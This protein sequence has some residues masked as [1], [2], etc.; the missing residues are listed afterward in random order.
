[1]EQK[2][3]RLHFTEEEL[4][5][6]SVAR[7]A[8]KAERTADKTD[9][10]KEKLPGRK[11]K[12]RHDED[13]ATQR[14]AQLRFGKK[15]FAEETTSAKKKKRPKRA[16]EQP[17]TAKSAQRSAS[18]TQTAGKHKTDVD[19]NTKSEP[20][21]DASLNVS[22]RSAVKRSS[23]AGT[24]KTAK[25]ESPAAS[26]R[27]SVVTPTE[28]E[29]L[30]VPKRTAHHAL[31]GAAAMVAGQIHRQVSEGNEDDNVGTQAAH[32]SEETVEG[33]AHAV[34]HYHYSRKLKAYDK[35]AKLERRSDK[36]NVEALYQNYRANHP[37]ASSNP[38]S[39]WRQ[40][41]ELH[42]AYLARKSGAHAPGSAASSA[43]TVES[44][45]EKAKDALKTVQNFIGGKRQGAKLLLILCA[46]LL[47]IV[48]MFQGCSSLFSGTVT[49]ITSTSWPAD[50]VEISKADAYYTKLEAQL[51]KKINQMESTNSSD[52]YNYSLAE[53]GHDST[54][55]ISYLSAKYGDFT[56]RE[57]KSELEAIFALQYDLDVETTE[58]TRTV[59]K[60]VRAG[61]YIGEVVTSGYCSCSIC[62]G[63]WAGGPTASGVYPTANHT[64]AVDA[65]NPTVPIG[66][67]IIMNGTLYKVEDTGAFD[68]Y[69]VDFDVY[70]DSHSA[71]QAHGHQT[72]D[73]YYAGGDGEE[74]EVTTT[75]DVTV[76]YV[77]LTAN[78]FESILTSRLTEEQ[79]ELYD[80]YQMTKGNRVFF[81]TP[82]GCDWHLNIV[83]NYGFRCE[84]TSIVE[85]DC[86]D[87][88]VLSGMDVL[89]VM[90]GTVKSISNNTVVLEAENDCQVK[91]VGCTDISVSVGSVVEKG[92]KIASVGS[93]G[94]LQIS[95]TYEGTSL[96][97]YFYLDTGEGTVY[98]EDVGDATGK[99]ALLI[100]K[101]KEY[102]G[103]PYVWGGYSPS[104][105]DCSGFVSYAVNNCGAGFS[106][107]RL[108]AEGWRQKCTIIS[109]SEA[110]P[111]DLIFFKGTYN[112]S[113]ASHI[114]IYLGN[115][116][117]IHAG[118]PVQ[119]SSINTSYWQQHFYCYGRIPGM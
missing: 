36:A 98:G 7:T 12:L 119:I 112:T 43:K 64:I 107:G 105:F 50:D 27:R 46:V 53:I 83:G 100:A 69:G 102:L 81:G 29:P 2:T 78:D 96:N 109:A 95:L 51:Q 92:Q 44:I 62:C 94:L 3:T 86:I 48:T 52:E 31:H 89:S 76:T 21:V 116:Q 75:E 56:L 114:G 65:D 19:G 33:A 115:G 117:M 87:V 73:A 118:N 74:I 17:S 60:T 39:R 8:K 9:A 103:V 113:G 104:G 85:S 15:Q 38:L 70:Y 80:V 58:E 22:G 4:E 34:E 82:L 111:G 30:T 71:A 35:A 55:L 77:T 10:A 18:P 14:E 66:T 1:M 91:L 5:A 37:E 57:V 72:W 67:E 26:V 47:L 97:P 40:K 11:T 23:P 45:G 68:Q 61:E 49:V 32:Q 24:Q 41:R 88:S 42:K 110:R 99:A 59:T 106:F 13:K 25:G 90:D 28:S 79:K 93:D 101:A 6:P 84:G 63:K 16:A 108:T 54:M 20:V